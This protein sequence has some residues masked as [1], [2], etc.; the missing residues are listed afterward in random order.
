M[1]RAKKTVVKRELVFVL[2]ILVIFIT[3]L[4]TWT[5]VGNVGGESSS[6]GSRGSIYEDNSGAQINIEVSPDPGNE[7]GVT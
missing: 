7:E 2:L 4:V 1:V 5:I 6:V 3:L